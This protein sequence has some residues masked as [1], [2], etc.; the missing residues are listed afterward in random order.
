MYGLRSSIRW[1]DTATYAVAGSNVD[2]QI[3]LNAPQGGKSLTFFVTSFHCAP[4]PLVF[5]SLRSWVPAQMRPGWIFE[6]SMLHTTS[7]LYW[8]RLSPTIPPFETTRAGSFVER[9]GLS[10]VQDWPPFDVFRIT[11]QP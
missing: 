8:P 2:G 9:S 11:W 7:P 1:N 3:S 10:S 5:Q 4:L 6:Y